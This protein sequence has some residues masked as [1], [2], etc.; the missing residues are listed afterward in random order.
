MQ[1]LSRLI[2]AAGVA[3]RRKCEELIRAGRVRVDGEVVTNVGAKADPARARIEVDGKPIAVEPPVYILLNKPRGPLSA[4]TDDRGRETVVG[5]VKGVKARLYPV[6]RLDGD[7]EGLLLLTNDGDLTY[8]L[9]HPRYQVDKVYQAEVKG[10]P[11]RSALERLRR[12]VMLSDGPSRAV[13]VRLLGRGKEG[14][15]VELTLHSGR[16]REVKRLLKAVGHPVARLRRV[17]VG[18][19]TLGGLTPGQWRR[20]SEEE[21]SRLWAYVQE[22]EAEAREKGSREA[23]RQGGR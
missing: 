12:G 15:R 9:T 14:A 22:R 17:R 16:K 3:S 4:V 18:P 2:A 23:N 19:L 6:G 5:L 20:L 10:V 8:R 7:T 21:V 1:R 11:D 13:R